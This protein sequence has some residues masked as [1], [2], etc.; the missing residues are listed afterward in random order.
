MTTAHI[1]FGGNTGDVDK[2]FREAEKYLVDRNVVIEQS[3]RTGTSAAVDCVPDTPDFKDKAYRILWHGSAEA[4]LDLLQETERHFGRPSDHRSDMSRTLDCDLI[5]FGNEV[6][7]T[8]R[9][10]VPH[11]RMH[12]RMFVLELM[13]E[14][15]PDYIHPTLKKTVRELYNAL[16]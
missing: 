10:T 14:T 11:P 8:E 16:A 15:A 13:I 4:L 7:N 6:I 12:E 5:F 2:T 1:M 9:L 3:S